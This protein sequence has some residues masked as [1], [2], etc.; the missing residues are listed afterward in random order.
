MHEAKPD[1]IE[2]R[3]IQFDN[4]RRLQYSTLNNL[5]NN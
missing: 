2:G 1:R 5:Q 3:E 4:N